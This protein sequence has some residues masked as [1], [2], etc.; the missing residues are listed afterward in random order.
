MNADPAEEPGWDVGP[1]DESRP[2][3]VALGRQIKTWREQAGISAAELG[4][5]LGYGEA[6]IFKVESGRRIPRPELLD[7]LDGVLNA[8]GKIAAMKQDFAEATY[9]K[10][11]R[12]L[13]ELERRAVEIGLYSNHNI[14]GLLQTEEYARAL[15]EMRQP[16]YTEAQVDRVLAA[17]MARRSV[18]LRSPA[19][20]LSFVQEEVSLQRPLGGRIIFRRQLESLLA[21]AELRNVTLQVMPTAVESHPGMG[22]EIEMLK[23]GDGSTV[24]RDGGQAGGRPLSGPKELQILELRYGMIRAQ[25]LTPQESLAFIEHVLG[26]T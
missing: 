10:K 25:A 15:F 23:F 1:E 5:R 24:G 14:H 11:V 9:P 3:L 8:C 26:E 13:A 17:R 21:V 2:M 22:G 12:E 16:T 20:A 19:P 18:F 4:E 7:Q 6:L